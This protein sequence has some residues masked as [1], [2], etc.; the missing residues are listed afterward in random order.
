MA[1][2]CLPMPALQ[3]KQNTT[4]ENRTKPNSVQNNKIKKLNRT[5]QNRL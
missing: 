2:I 5:E 1:I 4:E 3:H